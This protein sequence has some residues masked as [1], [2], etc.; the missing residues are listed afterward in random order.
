MKK[1]LVVLLALPVL[2]V[3]YFLMPKEG[4][5]RFLLTGSSTVAPAAAPYEVEKG[6][7]DCEAEECMPRRLTLL[8]DEPS[9]RPVGR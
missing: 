9:E 5:E 4:P 1:S 6:L 7:E 2:G 8:T 3:G